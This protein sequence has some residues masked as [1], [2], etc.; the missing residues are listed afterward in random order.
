MSRDAQLLTCTW[1]GSNNVEVENNPPRAATI[2]GNFSARST[3]GITYTL[4]HP[5]YLFGQTSYDQTVRFC[6]QPPDPD[7]EDPDPL[8]D[9]PWYSDG[10]GDDSDETDDDHDEHL[11]CYWGTCDGWCGCG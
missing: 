11:C 10:D 4:S 8:E 5:Q 9:P 7:P 6:P 3:S 1:Q 2:T